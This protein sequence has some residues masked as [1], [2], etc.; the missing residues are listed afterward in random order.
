ML[1]FETLMSFVRGKV[2]TSMGRLILIV[3]LLMSVPGC[4]GDEAGGSAPGLAHVDGGE[5]DPIIT[6]TPTPTGVTA[7]VTWEPPP[8]FD[9]ARYHIYYGKHSL[10]EA[11]S[12]ESTSEELGAEESLSCSQGEKQAVDA[13]SATITGLEPDTEYFFAIRALNENESESLCSNEIVAR[14]PSA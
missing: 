11:G 13:S 5:E 12:E 14:T 8:D 3:P 9:A 7:H 10:E 4:A 6:M 2:N 1:T